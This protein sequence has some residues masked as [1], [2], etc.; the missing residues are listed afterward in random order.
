MIHSFKK[1]G[2]NI[3]IDG[4]SGE[5]FS[6]DKLGYDFINYIQREIDIE[7]NKQ[8]K[9]NDEKCDNK[10]ILENFILGK[11]NINYDKIIDGFSKE[12][13]E[14]F[15]QDIKDTLDDIIELINEDRL[16]AND[17][18]IEIASRVKTEIGVLKA[19]CLHVA[20]DCNMSCGYCFAGKG[21][22]RGEKSLMSLETA[23]QAIDFLIANSKDR[24]NLEVDFFGGE[25]LLNWEVCKATVKYAKSI[26]K[27]HNK[28]FR[29]TLTT[30]GLLIDDDVIKFS[31]EHMANVVLS[32]DGTKEHNDAMRKTK[33][34]HGTY[35]LV[36]DKFKKLVESR[37]GRDYYIRGTYTK[38]NINFADDIFH[39]AKEGFKELSMEPVV[40]NQEVD[41]RL[42]EADLDDIK[43]NYDSLADEIIDR[44]EKDDEFYFYHYTV[45]F[46]KGPCLSKRLSGCGVGTEYLAITPNGDIY[47]C[48]QFVGDDKYLLG[49]LNDELLNKDIINEFLSSNMYTRD[50]CPSCFA[51]LYCSGGCSANA[52]HQNGDINKVYKLSCDIHKNRIENAIIIEFEKQN[53]KII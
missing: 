11:N 26:E 20:H 50:D 24:H 15:I 27:K 51:K 18:F 5:I 21:D 40:T 17:E 30:N 12:F 32:L 47:P 1:R 28:N 22:Y 19:I 36:I 44:I 14:Y 31:N 35:E 16:F 25:P 34:G 38:K 39:L 4:N 48:H 23:K 45:D 33:S 7:T 42:T 6:L 2:Y 52:F 37:N 8:S 13:K 41:Y 49:N 3:V 10:Y 53:K 9:K 46:A 43:R 29:F